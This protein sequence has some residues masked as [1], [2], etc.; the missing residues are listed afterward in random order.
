[1]AAVRVGVEMMKKQNYGKI[2]Q[3]QQQQQENEIQ[4][5]RFAI[6]AQME[7]F[8]SVLSLSQRTERQQ[9]SEKSC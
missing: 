3:Q 9:R 6:P 5:K 2:T 7:T 1:M 4:I 8:E